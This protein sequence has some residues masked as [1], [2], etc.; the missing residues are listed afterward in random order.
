VARLLRFL[1]HTTP[2]A[3]VTTDVHRATDTTRVLQA[4]FATLASIIA[5]GDL[6]RFRAMSGP[7][8]PIDAAI[9]AFDNALNNLYIDLA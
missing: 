6:V 8:H 1:T 5:R 9:N 3:K 7:G 4:R 2:P